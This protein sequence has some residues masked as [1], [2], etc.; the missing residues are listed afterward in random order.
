MDIAEKRLRDLDHAQFGK[1]LSRKRGVLLLHRRPHPAL[2]SV[3]MDVGDPVGRDPI[4]AG[5]GLP[6]AGA[7][8]RF[9]PADRTRSR[10]RRLDIPHKAIEVP[11]CL[12]EALAQLLELPDTFLAVGQQS[13]DPGQ[14][15]RTSADAFL[16]PSLDFLGFLVGEHGDDEEKAKV[17]YHAHEPGGRAPGPALIP[18]L[19]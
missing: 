18:N 1:A 5:I 4:G 2:P 15:D 11:E 13:V 10:P 17:V 14:D 3:R 12:V 6:A 8:E 7:V 9:R 16:A 19:A